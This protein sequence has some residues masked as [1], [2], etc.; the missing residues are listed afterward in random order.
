MKSTFNHS[1]FGQAVDRFLRSEDGPTTVE[2]AETLALITIVCLTANRSIGTKAN[3]TFTNI[4]SSLEGRR[5]PTPPAGS[6]EAGAC[7]EVARD[8]R[9]SLD[10]LLQLENWSRLRSPEQPLRCVRPAD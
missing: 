3:P 6:K 8:L 10:L 7:S 4:A 5:S 1:Q 2:C 9:M